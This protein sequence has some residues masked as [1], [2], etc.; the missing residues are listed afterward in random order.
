MLL[1]ILTLLL[2]S[3]LGSSDCSFSSSTLTLDEGSVATYNCYGMNGA[4]DTS[5]YAQVQ[6]L[7]NTPSFHSYLATAND[8]NNTGCPCGDWYTCSPACATYYTG[9]THTGSDSSII[10]G[11]YSYYAT[12]SFGFL[13][14]Q[15]CW[16]IECDG[17]GA[18]TFLISQLK[19][20]GGQTCAATHTWRNGTISIHSRDTVAPLVPRGVPVAR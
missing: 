15:F 18:C 9:F 19:M 16:R 3:S 8:I 1:Q 4:L 2:L 7:N 12:S 11:P 10:E 17:P 20:C 6:C 13:R 5:V 14:T